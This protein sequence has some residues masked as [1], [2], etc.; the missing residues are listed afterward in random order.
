[1]PLDKTSLSESVSSS[2]RELS[3][4]AEAL[5]VVS[6]ALGKAVSD[7]DEGLK[8]L[9]LGVT[10]W[11]CVQEYGGSHEQDLTY[12]LEEL[13]YAKINGKWGIALR[14]RS[15]DEE[16]PEYDE[17]VEIWLFNEAAR[18]L[19]LKA[20]KKI[21]ELLT[22]LN[23]EATKITKELQA[24]LVEAQAVADAV[25]AAATGPK[26]PAGRARSVV[27]PVIP[28]NTP[29]SGGLTPPPG[30]PEVKK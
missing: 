30:Y 6:D 18:A 25:H 21:P 19:R 17:S 16:H 3:S 2:F 8:R 15:G 24:K 13:G 27:Q 7:I 4:A 9:N 14:V 23:E 22:K 20:I 1:M 26:A 10:A 12:T 5:N 29:A 28:L 11:V